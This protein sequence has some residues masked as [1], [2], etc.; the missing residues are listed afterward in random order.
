MAIT[1]KRGERKM[2]P[3]REAKI[4]NIRFKNPFKVCLPI[5]DTALVR[6][7]ESK[8]GRVVRSIVKTRLTQYAN[9]KNYK[10]LSFLGEITT[11]KRVKKMPKFSR[12]S[13]VSKK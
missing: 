8:R 12:K 11:I 5:C 13:T 2:I 1:A 10:L 9:I 7:E 6:E 3:K 4:S